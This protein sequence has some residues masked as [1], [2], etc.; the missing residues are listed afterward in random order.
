[1]VSDD[2]AGLV[3][4]DGRDQR[5]P[6][7]GRQR[8]DVGSVVARPSEPTERLFVAHDESHGMPD[9]SSSAPGVEVSRPTLRRLL[10]SRHARS[11]GA[12]FLTVYVVSFI[13]R[14]R[15]S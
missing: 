1:M 9:I 11:R 3:V 8:L 4:V 6:G 7:G 12:M 5:K 14:D 2:P 10:V 15:S 13:Y